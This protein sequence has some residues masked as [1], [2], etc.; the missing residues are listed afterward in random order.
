MRVLH[1]VDRFDYCDGCARH[2]YF[3]ARAQRRRGYEVAVVVG[4]GD[5]LE[6]LSAEQIPVSCVPWIGHESRSHRNFLR[7]MLA[8]RGVLK[9]VRP[10]IVHAHH[11]YA[12]HQVLSHPL[13]RPPRVVLTVHANISPE[14]RLS[15]YVG[16][17]IIAVSESTKRHIL[18]LDSSLRSK[19]FVVPNGSEFLGFAVEVRRMK[20][21]LAL[22]EL[23]R[24]RFVVGFVGRLVE[25][26]GVH[27]LLEAIARLRENDR[28]GCVI[29]GSGDFESVLHQR[30]Q[31]LSL[32]V[33]FFPTVRDVQPI[34]EA[35][36]LVVIPSLRDEGLPMSLI[37]AGLL[38][39]PVIG[40][41]IDGIADTIVDGLSGLL[42]QPAN[43]DDLASAI[44]RV[45]N[46]PALARSLGDNLHTEVAKNHV[47]ARMVDQV[48]AVYQSF[49]K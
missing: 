16:D 12:A 38:A 26:K 32:D 42:V 27:I 33:I 36:D 11:Y 23:K 9:S 13:L 21:F 8:M 7:G 1:V 2:V 3:L 47:V 34:L 5:A 10:D 20:E 31:A 29:V 15:H 44:A 48:D 39:K 40:S 30:A 43:V 6:L 28:V 22:T 17:R 37:E 35:C 4:R 49:L 25:M 19:L 41:A 18:A 45:R 46:S 24:R 14:G